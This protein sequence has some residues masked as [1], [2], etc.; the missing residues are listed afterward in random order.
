MEEHCHNI[1]K[2]VSLNKNNKK[3]PGKSSYYTLSD[4]NKI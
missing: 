3:K 4:K 2:K 1:Y